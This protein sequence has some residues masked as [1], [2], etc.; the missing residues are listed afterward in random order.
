MK[1][2]FS[3]LLCFVL[4]LSVFAGCTPAEQT[5][6]ETTAAP[7]D[8]AK[9]TINGVEL[10]K[11]TIV[12]SKDGL[13]SQIRASGSWIES[14]RMADIAKILSD[15]LFE[16]TGKRLS[17]CPDDGQTSKYEILI[18]K[19]ERKE[20]KNY[21]KTFTLHQEKYAYGMFEEKLVIA[22]GS[23]NACYFAIMAW[24]ED[25]KN[26]TGNDFNA[27]MVKG[28]EE[29]IQVA[30]IGD[31]IT[32]GVGYIEGGETD[33]NY[34]SYPVYLQ[35]LLGY[36]YYVGNYGF[37]SK[38]MTDFAMYNNFFQ[39]LEAKPDVVT[40]MLGT[41]DSGPKHTGEKWGTAEYKQEYFDACDSM[42]SK[43][44][45]ANP[46]VQIF[47]MTPLYI[48]REDH[49]KRAELAI[50]YDKE[51]AELLNL[52]FVDMWTPSKDGQWYFYDG[53]HPQGEVYGQV[54]EAVY[55]GIKD[56]IKKPE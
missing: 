56:T 23:S 27:E 50:E 35:R 32:D 45:A 28:Q 4:V 41:N 7:L 5:P 18:G 42:V 39:S 48:Y 10:A 3:L 44:R 6:T 21:Y 43:Y 20:S 1:R 38:L 26:M 9:L 30:C 40:I 8:P 17:V 24:L 15:E 33:R 11:Y 2:I 12:Y 51:L 19:T 31:S 47:I 46:D 13:H 16:L 29:L 55:N 54:G 34:Y 49:A 36:K 53:L 52:E 37:G 25:I 22:G 14:G